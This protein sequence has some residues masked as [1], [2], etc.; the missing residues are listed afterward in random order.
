MTPKRTD[1][2][3]LCAVC[4]KPVEFRSM[5]H[6]VTRNI[7]EYYVECHGSSDQGLHL[8]QDVETAHGAVLH[9]FPPPT[10]TFQEPS[11]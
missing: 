7:Y 8:I 2:T 5:M 11:P 1:V 9:A 3:I 4:N 10:T 6:N